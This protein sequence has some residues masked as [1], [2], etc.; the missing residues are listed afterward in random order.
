[1]TSSSRPKNRQNN[2]GQA[3][4]S[5]RRLAP[6]M[7]RTATPIMPRVMAFV[8]D[9]AGVG[10]LPDAAEYGDSSRV[11]T[12]GNVAERLGGLRLPNFERLG[13]GIT[14]PIRGVIPA[15]A[16]TAAVGRMRE[17]SH[18]KDTITGHWEMVGIVTDVPFP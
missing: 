18:G 14:T 7:D 1:M 2:V 17:R 5:S 3:V 16:P 4:H 8:M 11:N 12:I 15:T 6:A 13:L 9:S 10:A